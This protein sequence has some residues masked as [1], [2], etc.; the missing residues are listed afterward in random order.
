MTRWSEPSWFRVLSGPMTEPS[1]TDVLGGN[2]QSQL[3]S[4]IERAENLEADKAGVMADLKEV[5]AEAK[6]NG[7]DVKIIRKVI[8]LRKMDRAKRAEE[9]AVLDLYMSAIGEA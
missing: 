8:R 6:G 5:F 9:E 2:A 7:F 4:I 1:S 3:R